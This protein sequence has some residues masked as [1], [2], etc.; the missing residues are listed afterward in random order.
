[1]STPC[2]SL[3]LYPGYMLPAL[4]V[5]P[6]RWYKLCNAHRYWQEVLPL[7]PAFRPLVLAEMLRETGFEVCRHFTCL[8]F[9]ETPLR[10]EMRLSRF[11]ELL[12]VRSHLGLL[13]RASL[14]MPKRMIFCTV[15]TFMSFML[16]M[17]KTRR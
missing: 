10:L 14:A 6:G 2:V 9:W 5:M 13:R 7:H 4:M 3:H 17:V 11:L 8:W 1:M 15:L 16:F 12:R